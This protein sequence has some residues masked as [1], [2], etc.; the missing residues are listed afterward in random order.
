MGNLSGS[1]I[2]GDQPN[3]E[4]PRCIQ[5]RVRHCRTRGV[6][7]PKYICDYIFTR[8]TFSVQRAETEILRP[9]AAA[10]PQV[11]WSPDFAHIDLR[12]IVADVSPQFVVDFE[13][14]FPGLVER[15]PITGA[16]TLVIDSELNL[17][18]AI[19]EGID[20]GAI[21]TLDTS[22]FG[23]GDFG[24]F[25][26]TLNGTYLSRFEFQA[27][28]SAKRIGLSGMFVP[29]GST[30]SG[31]LPHNRAFVSAFYDGPTNTWLSGF[32]IGATVHYTGQYEDDNIELVG[33]KP[34][35]PRTEPKLIPGTNILNP[36][37]GEQSQHARK[38]REWITLD[39]IASYTFNLPSPA[40]AKV[41]GLAK[42]GGKNVK[43]QDGKAKNVLPVSTAEYNPC[44]WR[45]W[46]NGTTITLGMQNVLDTDPPFVAGFPENNYD[47]SL[48]TIKGRFWY[49]Q[50][51]K[52]F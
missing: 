31:S 48:A 18:R 49:V 16:I 8:A 38:V 15:D 43:M 30:F 10:R 1:A 11:D 13:N 42:D 28:P 52:R 35:T 5:P 4:L 23:R 37:A 51:K 19:A 20:Y 29:L 21:Y 46:L 34:Q 3:L 40:A 7:Q 32:D 36:N 2:S 17:A 24:R 6:V 33:G 12:S 44:G 45:S 27:T 22:M 39:L 26:F 14:Q 47:E 41:P 25:T 50:L 9:V